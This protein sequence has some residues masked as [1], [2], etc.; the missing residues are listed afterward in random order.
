MNDVK[1][2][3]EMIADSIKIF[4]TFVE[5][6][7]AARYSGSFKCACRAAGVFLECNGT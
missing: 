1:S 5:G 6:V 3:R 2:W 7:K 4:K